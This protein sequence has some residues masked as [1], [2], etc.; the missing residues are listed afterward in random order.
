ML[1]IEAAP[2]RRMSL[3]WCAAAAI[4]AICLAWPLL[5]DQFLATGMRAG[6]SPIAFRPFGVLGTAFPDGLRRIWICRRT[7][8]FSADRISR[9]LCH[10][11]RFVVGLSATEQTGG[12]ADGEAASGDFFALL[13][14]ASLACAG[15]F[16]STIGNNNDL[17]WRAV[18]PGVI[19]LTV[20]AAVG[21]SRWIAARAAGRRRRGGRAGRGLPKAGARARERRGHSRTGRQGVRTDARDVGCGAPARGAR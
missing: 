3:C 8:S 20:F 6:G 14:A 15:L 9:R 1:L 10:R 7:G 11:R 21:L 4:L 16:A 2:R 18:L 13:A 19:V 12:D 5:H 17:G